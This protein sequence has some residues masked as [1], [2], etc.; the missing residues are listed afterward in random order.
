M[1]VDIFYAQ[2]NHKGNDDII[3]IGTNMKKNALRTTVGVGQNIVKIFR[4]II[5][6]WCQI[7]LSCYSL[8]GTCPIQFIETLD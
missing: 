1:N 8:P 7:M 5:T 4:K 6:L 3:Y 2:G